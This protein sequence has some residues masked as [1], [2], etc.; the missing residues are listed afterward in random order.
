M[1]TS[2]LDS[3]LTL[4]AILVLLAAGALTWVVRQI[5]PDGIE[6]TKVWRVVLRIL[7]VALG[8][9]LACI[10]HLWPMGTL[11]QSIVVGGIAGSFSSTL[12][13]VIRESLGV[14]IKAAMGSPQARKS[15]VPTPDK[16][17]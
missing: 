17:E 6:K 16:P 13:E 11:S 2:I 15:I 10:P 1:E 3:I 8:C 5:I 4:N 7:P 14:K 12:Y 9:G